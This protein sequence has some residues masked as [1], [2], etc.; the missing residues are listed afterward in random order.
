MHFSN[1]KHCHMTSIGQL[2]FAA[3]VLFA[4]IFVSGCGYAK[5]GPAAYELTVA[6]DQA[7]ERRSLEQIGKAG[8]IIETRQDAGEITAKEAEYL[9]AVVRTAESGD[10]TGARQQ[11][12][13][14]LKDQVSW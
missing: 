3:V 12:L 5:I 8:V 14:I 13:A 10:W 6:L 1:R 4:T 11:T 7:V 9:N 2:L